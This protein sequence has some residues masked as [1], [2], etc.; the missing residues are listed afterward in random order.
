MK[1]HDDG[2]AMA[3]VM[4][5][6]IKA[7]LQHKKE[8][9]TRRSAEEKIADRVTSFT[10]TMKFV[11]IHAVLFSV[12]ILWNLGA[13]GLP[14]FDP[15]FVALAMFASVEAIFL[16]T[17]VLISQN[18]SNAI[19]DKRAELDLQISLLTEHEVTKILR[20]VK[21]IARQ[22]GIETAYD[23][24]LDELAQDV[25]PEKVIDTMEKVNQSEEDLHIS[26]PE[27]L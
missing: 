25:Q 10:G 20:M 15:T 3:Q 23:A 27:Q 19:A 16:S 4:E 24:E 26:E 2:P 18:R 21:D 6:N 17:F 22:T 12:W 13:L 9:E 11:Y 7:L 8:Q 14:R 1:K 5:R